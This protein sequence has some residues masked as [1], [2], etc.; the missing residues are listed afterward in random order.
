MAMKIHEANLINGSESIK[1]LLQAKSKFIDN[2]KH[3]YKC[4]YH[5]LFRLQSAVNRHAE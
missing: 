5:L 4:G 3:A 1:L 2:D